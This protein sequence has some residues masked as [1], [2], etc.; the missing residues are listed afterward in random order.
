MLTT[1][2]SILT[3]DDLKSEIVLIPEWGDSVRVWMLTG[4]DRDAY[5]QLL[6]EQRGPD[7]GTNVKNIRARL[8][9]FCVRDDN[10]E[11]LFLDAEIDALGK[12]NAKALDRIYEVAYRLNAFGRRE[13]EELAGN[14]GGGQAAAFVSDSPAT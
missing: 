12:K 9:A 13:V 2:E 6:I 10:N 14:S 3:K 8:A 5:E 1:K 4:A 7:V 11:R